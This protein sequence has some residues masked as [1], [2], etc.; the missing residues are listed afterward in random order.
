METYMVF[1]K[2]G[3]VGTVKAM[4]I[5]DAYRKSSKCDA[6]SGVMLKSA[7]DALVRGIAEANK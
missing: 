1:Y 2:D 4:G 3:T 7:Y 5:Y 6:V